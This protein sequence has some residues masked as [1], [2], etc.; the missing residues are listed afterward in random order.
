MGRCES[1]R[2]G[3]RGGD[4]GEVGGDGQEVVVGADISCSVLAPLPCA[5]GDGALRLYLSI[6]FSCYL[7]IYL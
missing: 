4:G 6:Y 5:S 3:R 2:R 1:C 7:L